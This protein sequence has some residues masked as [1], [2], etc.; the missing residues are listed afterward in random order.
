MSMYNQNKT[1]VAQSLYDVGTVD[2]QTSTC[3][4]FP[5]ITAFSDCA[6]CNTTFPYFASDECDVFGTRFEAAFA[7]LTDRQAG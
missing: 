1:L 5:N 6:S 4:Q 2:S 7:R 3:P